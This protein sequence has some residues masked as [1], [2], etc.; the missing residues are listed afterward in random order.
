MPSRII[1]ETIIISESLTAISAEAERFFWRLVVKADDFGLYYGDPRIL[2]S[3]CFPQKPPSEQKI[4][5]W[6]NE[7]VREDMVGTY[8]APEDGKKYLKLLNWGK[9][10]QTRAKSSK[11]PEP[12]SFD[13]KCKQANRNQMLA[14]VPVN[15]N[16]NENGNDNENEKRAQTGRGAADGFDRFWASYPRRVGKKDAV[17]VWKK[18]SPDDTLVDR[19]V[20]GVERWKRSEQWTKDDGRFIPYPAT[21]LRG[22]R[23]NESDSVSKPAAVPPAAKDYGDGDDFLGGDDHE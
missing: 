22:E 20:A 13:S 23:W 12:S 11:Y 16:E 9:C 7:L 19:I 1:K 15:V 21:F 6:L 4:R 3:L 18:I 2:A 8:T 14:N 10:Q 5:S 17:A